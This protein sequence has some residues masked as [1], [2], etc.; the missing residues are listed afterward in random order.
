MA[1]TP[2]QGQRRGLF[3]HLLAAE[4]TA[5]EPTPSGCTAEDEGMGFGLD[6]PRGIVGPGRVVDGGGRCFLSLKNVFFFK[7]K[8]NCF[9]EFCCFLSNFNMNQP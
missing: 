7:L 8:D 6:G 3:R 1:P 2:H 9:T 4:G 5:T